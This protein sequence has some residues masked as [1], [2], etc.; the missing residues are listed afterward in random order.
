M[1]DLDSNLMGLLEGTLFLP[2]RAVDVI[3]WLCIV[4][5]IGLGV[6]AAVLKFRK[7]RQDKVHILNSE[8]V[9]GAEE[10]STAE[11]EPNKLDVFGFRK[12]STNTRPFLH[13]R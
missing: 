12:T 7:N 6:T 2:I 9:E 13:T 8:E 4:I 3:K 11:F 5:G 1:L 10:Q